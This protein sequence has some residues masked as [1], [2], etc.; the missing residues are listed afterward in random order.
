MTTPTS[1]TSA[2]PVHREAAQWAYR[3]LWSWLVRWLR[4]PDQPPTLPANPGQLHES[5]QPSRE[6]LSYMK[7]NFWLGLSFLGGILLIVWIVLLFVKPVVGIALTAPIWGI[8]L[9]PALITY[10][11]I[12]LRYDTMWYVVTDRSMR[13]RRGLWSIHE[14]TITFENVQTV[15]VSQ[16]PLQRWYGIGNVEVRTA[17]GGT[18]QTAQGAQIE[19]SGHHGVIEGVTNAGEIRDLILAQLKL[20]KTTGL[21]DEP[22]AHAAAQPLV[23]P[24]G[25]AISTKHLALLREIRDALATQA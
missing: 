8:I 13:V 22:H 3:G 10:L 21:G 4:V 2:T 9:V 11:S 15:K 7:F 5:F 24:S 14:V 17:G 18:L 1:T 23:A 20:A 12:H 16:G 25:S 6:Y 19:G